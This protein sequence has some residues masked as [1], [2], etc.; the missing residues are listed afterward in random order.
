MLNWLSN[1]LLGHTQ[2]MKNTPFCLPLGI[3]SAPGGELAT[4]SNEKSPY[5]TPISINRYWH[6][7]STNQICMSSTCQRTQS[8]TAWCL[9]KF[10]LSFHKTV[11][12]DRLFFSHPYEL[13]VLNPGCTLVSVHSTL[14]S[15]EKCLKYSFL[16]SP[17]TNQKKCEPRTCIFSK[18]PWG[19]S[20]VHKSWE[21]LTQKY[22][23]SQRVPRKI[24][25]IV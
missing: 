4:N 25:I 8:S 11:S 23:G 6:L 18:T 13:L 21:A 19:S 22:T 24:Q 14:A 9:S 1:H 15:P 3:P 12:Y 5:A 16:G 7:S 20:Y 10:E 2:N 17:Q